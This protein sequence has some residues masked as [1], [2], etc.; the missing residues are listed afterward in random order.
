MKYIPMFAATTLAS[1]VLFTGTQSVY[2]AQITADQ[3]EDAVEKYTNNNT[4]YQP[5]DETQFIHVKDNDDHIEG[6]FS[7]AFGQEGDQAPTFL[8]VD[9]TTGDIYSNDGNLV[10]KGTAQNKQSQQSSNQEAEQTSDEQSQHETQ[11]LPDTGN[12]SN[13]E[14]GGILAALLLAVGSVLIMRPKYKK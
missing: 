11:T 3:A 6:T 12:M 10:E 8:Y 4:A 1:T 9:K 14:T 7:I 5:K 13:G 2:A